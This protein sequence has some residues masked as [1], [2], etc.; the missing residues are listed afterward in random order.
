VIQAATARTCWAVALFIASHYLGWPFCDNFNAIIGVMDKQIPTSIK[1]VDYAGKYRAAFMDLNVEWI[2]KYFVMEPSDYKVLE[3][4]EG[5]IL[6]K[7]GFIYVA[8]ENE[9]AAGVCA[10]IKMN[11]GEYDYELAKMAVAPSFQGRG[12]GRLLGEAAIQKAKTLNATKIYLGS[13]VMLKT[14]LR[15]YQK[16]GFKEIHG[17][18][19]PYVR[20]NVQMELVLNTAPIA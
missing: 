11:D 16:L 10:M 3:N 1:V 14:A 5:Y 19:T 4:P 7:G 2:S 12:I 15:L 6:D 20:C 17:R 13:N 8:L 9:T 18:P